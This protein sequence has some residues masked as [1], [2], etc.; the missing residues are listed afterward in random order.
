MGVGIKRFIL[1]MIDSCEPVEE[2]FEE[3]ELIKYSYIL[4]NN[5]SIW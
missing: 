4:F 2:R 5:S 3:F 1:I